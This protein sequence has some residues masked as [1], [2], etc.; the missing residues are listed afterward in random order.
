[1][2]N[3]KKGHL[4]SHFKVIIGMCYR[5]TR[6]QMDFNLMNLRQWNYN[7]IN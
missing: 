4:A 2:H 7:K 3:D 5:T 6:T 1:M